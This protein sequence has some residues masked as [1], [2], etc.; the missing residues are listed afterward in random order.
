MKA[1]RRMSNRKTFAVIVA[2][3]GLSCV[4]VG[5]QEDALESVA[6][7]YF[8]VLR[9]EGTTSDELEILGVVPEGE[10]RHVLARITLGADQ[11]TVTEF[12]V[13]SFFP[14]EGSWRLQLN[15]EMQGS[16]AALASQL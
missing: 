4:Q 12:E 13:L 5:A 15:G 14:F 3:L 8:D 7:A 10:Q 6:R 16:A 1:N 9:T 2:A 11:L